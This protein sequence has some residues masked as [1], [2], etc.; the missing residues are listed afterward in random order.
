MKKILAGGLL[1]LVM[2]IPLFGESSEIQESLTLEYLFTQGQELSSDYIMATYDYANILLGANQQE[3]TN[4]FRWTVTTGDVTYY[5]NEGD[6]PTPMNLQTSSD[7]KAQKLTGSPGI[8]MDIPRS[9]TTLTLGTPFSVDLHNNDYST[10]TPSFQLTQDIISPQKYERMATNLNVQKMLLTAESSITIALIQLENS[11]LTAISELFEAQ[12]A[13]EKALQS[14]KSADLNF[15]QVVEVL[16]YTEETT[17]YQESLMATLEV[18]QGVDFALFELTQAQDNLELLTGYR[19]LPLSEFTLPTPSPSIDEM[20]AS[21]S[22]MSTDLDV[23]LADYNLQAA[24][25]GTSFGLS[26]VLGG[27]MTV[28]NGD[29]LDSNISTGLNAQVGDGLTFG[30]SAA[31]NLNRKDFLGGV[32]FSYTPQ[33]SQHG[34]IAQETA[35]NSYLQAVERRNLV[36]SRYSSQKSQ[37]KNQISLWENS[38]RLAQRRYSVAKNQYD[39][40]TTLF[41]EGYSTALSLEEKALS[42]LEAENSVM[43]ALIKGLLL[44]RGIEL[45]YNS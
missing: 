43:Q 38:Y 35:E 5:W 21:T 16:G 29:V 20:R 4:A 17:T 22:L 9:G 31:T 15:Q 26:G 33:V 34:N 23:S 28:G 42:L 8:V 13:Y 39:Q 14:Q 45:F 25:A 7:V 30:V 27:N 41:E 12:V 1:L 32:S 19:A 11:V 10:V 44:E 2:G 3:L 18:A 37:F 40:E 36:E 6:E 24:E